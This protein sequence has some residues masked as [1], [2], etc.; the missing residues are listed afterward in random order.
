MVGRHVPLFERILGQPEQ[1]RPRRVHSALP[2]Q[3][4]SDDDELPL[5]LRHRNLLPL[6][7]EL[8]DEGVEIALRPGLGGA[9][10]HVADVDAVE[11]LAAVIVDAGDPH[12]RR[13]HVDVGHRRVDPA[14]SLDTPRGPACS[15][16]HAGAAL[17]DAALGA[18]VGAVVADAD[19]ASVVAE[20]EDEGVLGNAVAVDRIEDSADAL[21][22][23]VDHR[24]VNPAPVPPPFVGGDRPARRRL[25]PATWRLDRLQVRVQR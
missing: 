24:G 20:E 2:D 17:E 7:V 9:R 3:R 10:E 25:L 5:L 16:G 19:G 13:Q 6:R 18:P 23:R 11:R 14:A 15:R 8:G 4:R 12:Q 21:V 22:Q 1:H